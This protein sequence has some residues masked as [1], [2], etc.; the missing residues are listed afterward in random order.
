M[1]SNSATF[2]GAI[3]IGAVVAQVAAFFARA[4][5]PTGAWAGAVQD[6]AN[7]LGAMAGVTAMGN[8]SSGP[9]PQGR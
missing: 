7:F 6:T 9:P 4:A 2:R 1:L 3:Y 5:D 8:L